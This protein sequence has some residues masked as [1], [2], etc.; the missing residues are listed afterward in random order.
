MINK[1]KHYWQLF[2]KYSTF[3]ALLLFGILI[4]I[5][6]PKI[7]KKRIFRDSPLK[8][9]MEGI[10]DEIKKLKGNHSATTRRVDER[11]TSR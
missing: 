3:I 9:D 6:S 11:F 2:K 5:I 1:I 10:K 7:Y 8:E 4:W